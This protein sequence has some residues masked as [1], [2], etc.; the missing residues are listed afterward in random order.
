MGWTYKDW[1]LI[2]NAAGQLGPAME[3]MKRERKLREQEEMARQLLGEPLEQYQLKRMQK[4]HS[5]EDEMRQLKIDE[6]RRGPSE[7]PYKRLNYEI[8]MQRL[9]NDLRNTDSLIRERE[10]GP[11]AKPVPTPII[12]GNLMYNGSTWGVAPEAV[13]KQQEKLS[14]L[15]A[16]IARLQAAAD[17]GNEYLGPEKF[18]IGT[19]TSQQLSAKRATR[20]AL[21]GSLP[22]GRPS[23]AFRERMTTART[24]STASS[25]VSDKKAIAQQALN[26]PESTEAERAQARKI[27]GL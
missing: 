7:D 12:E 25:G 4:E 19:P 18:K 22:K 16:D 5:L 1:E 21:A 6:M 14:K 15:D 11:E 3:R 26:D 8:Q 9:Q 27:L 24:P 23:D 17:A 10:R 13:T 2:Q 20:E